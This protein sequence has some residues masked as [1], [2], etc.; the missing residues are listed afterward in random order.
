MIKQVFRLDDTIKHYG[1]ITSA[2]S[3]PKCSIGNFSARMSEAMKMFP[4]KRVAVRRKT[5][6]RYGD[7]PIYYRYYYNKQ[8]IKFPRGEEIVKWMDEDPQISK[9]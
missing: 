7:R 6:N 2:D 4:I 5:P 1:S 8:D 9:S 3:I